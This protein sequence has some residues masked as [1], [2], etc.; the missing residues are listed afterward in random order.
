MLIFGHDREIAQ[1]CGDQLGIKDFGPCS[2]IG[3]AREGKIVAG[4]VFSNF[5]WPNIEITFA[6]TTP[7]WATRETC[8][9]IISYPFLQL[10]CRRV[11]AIIEASNQPARAFLSRFGF[12]Q[13]GYHPHVFA[14]GDAITFGLLAADA[15]RWLKEPKNVQGRSSSTANS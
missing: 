12:K 6:T 3:V 11:T 9:A 15:E 14:S 7:R 10:R 13:E 8:N 5:R 2:A 1:W 4:A